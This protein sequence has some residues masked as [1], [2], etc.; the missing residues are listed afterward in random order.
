M[1]YK[2]L[3]SIISKPWVTTEDI[4]QI[5]ACG[6]NTATQIRW[7]IEKIIIDSGKKLPVSNK[8]HVPTRLVL[9]YLGLDEEYIKNMS[10]IA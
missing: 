5:A 4:M 8:K 2:Q 9:N 6:R 7:D 10:S 1:S 3:L